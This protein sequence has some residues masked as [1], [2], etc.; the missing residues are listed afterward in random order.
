MSREEWWREVAKLGVV[1][2]SSIRWGK[3]GRWTVT[4]ATEDAQGTASGDDLPDVERAALV[5]LRNA[6]ALKYAE[7]SRGW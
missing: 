6:L 1:N 7:E 3:S 5:D 2:V 4:I